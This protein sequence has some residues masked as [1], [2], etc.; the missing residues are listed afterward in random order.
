MTTRRLAVFDMDGT[1]L[2]SLPDLAECSRDLLASYA[3]P[4][5]SDAEVRGMIGEGVQVLVTRALALA[6]RKQAALTGGPVTTLPES[7]QAAERFMAFYTPRAA[8]LSRLFPGTEDALHALQ[9]QGWSLAICTN[10][11][12]RAAR[13]ILDTLGVAALFAAVGGGDSFAARKPDPRH[14]LGTI[15]QAGGQ[16]Q[17]SVMIGDMPPDWLAAEGAGCDFVFAAWGYGVT[18]PP[19]HSGHSAPLARSMAQVPV[20]L[21]TVLP[22]DR[23]RTG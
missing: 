14:L 5:I 15:V 6:A 9:A 8:R 1:L 2:D 21:E 22:P 19:G 11:P 18:P 16:V 4:P 12:E 7:A 23:I 17:R 13:G 3:L 20:T 10:K